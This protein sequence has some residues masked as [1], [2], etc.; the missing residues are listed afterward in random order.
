MGSAD[1]LGSPTA[2]GRPRRALLSRTR[3]AEEALRAGDAVV[4]GWVGAGRSR[5]LDEIERLLRDDGRTVAVARPPGPESVPVLPP[6]GYLGCL[7]GPALARTVGGALHEIVESAAE[8]V[9]TLAGS[10]RIALL[11]DDLHRAD[12][13]SLAVLPVL[14]RRLSA[15]VISAV[16][17]AP[18]VPRPRVPVAAAVRRLEPSARLHLG[19]LDREE[20]REVLV[21]GG[22]LPADAEIGAL[23]SALVGLDAALGT[24]RR[25]PGLLGSVGA[26]GLLPGRH[27]LVAELS[28]RADGSAQLI[29][30]AHALGGLHADDFGRLAGPVEN[31]GAQ[32]AALV[33]TVT[34]EGWLDHRQNRW[35]CTVPALGGALVR[36]LVGWERQRLLLTLLSRGYGN[37]RIAARLGVA[38]K[39]IESMLTRLLAEHECTNRTELVAR[40]LVGDMSPSRAR[41]T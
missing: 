9:A 27:P 30:F 6:L 22:R 25:S 2:T 4:T 29:A 16:R 18:T 33:D 38:E 24:A 5:L 17:L 34:D 31:D 12:D 13:V 8:T 23:V 41:T 36:T 26:D 21:A 7:A 20:A 19:P 35:H 15:H 14:R 28:A 3:A 40:Y 1:V 37:T 39:T 32:A 11:C 10:G